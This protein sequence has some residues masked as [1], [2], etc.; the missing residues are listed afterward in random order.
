MILSFRSFLYWDEQH[1]KG[2]VNKEKMCISNSDIMEFLLFIKAA[3][4][5]WYL[6]RYVTFKSSLFFILSSKYS[7]KW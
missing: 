4:F 7:A 2:G 3:T 6:F 1:N 5:W